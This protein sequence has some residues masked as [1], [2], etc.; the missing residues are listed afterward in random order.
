[1]VCKELGFLGAKEATTQSQ[2]GYVNETFAMDSIVCDE[3][4][5]TLLDCE[6]ETDHNC[7][8]NEGAGVIC[9][10]KYSRLCTLHYPLYLS[11]A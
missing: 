4:D 1:M 10:G 7:W 9:M 11:Y 5:A 3:N 2:F 8:I 6:Y